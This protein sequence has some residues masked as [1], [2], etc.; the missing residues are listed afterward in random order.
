LAEDKLKILKELKEG[1]IQQEG[2]IHYT[3]SLGR[4]LLL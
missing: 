3:F 1:M 2:A 4:K